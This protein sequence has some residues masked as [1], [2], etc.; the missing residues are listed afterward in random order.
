MYN[1][2]RGTSIAKL[3]SRINFNECR[4]VDNKDKGTRLRIQ[5]MI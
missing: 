2:N 1:I 5:V 4:K 3:S